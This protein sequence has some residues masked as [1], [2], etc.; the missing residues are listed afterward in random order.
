MKIQ[1]RLIIC[2]L[3][4]FAMQGLFV[5]LAQVYPVK[6]EELHGARRI[7]DVSLT[8]EEIVDTLIKITEAVEQNNI[9]L[10]QVLIHAFRPLKY[11]EHWQDALGHL[12]SVSWKAWVYRAIA[13]TRYRLQDY[14]KAVEFDVKAAEEFLRLGIKIEAA[15]S[16]RYAAINSVIGLRDYRRA[17]DYNVKSSDLYFEIGMFKEAAN[18]YEIAATMATTKLNDYAE[19]ETCRAKANK[20]Y[21]KT[22]IS[23][24]E[25]MAQVYEKKGQFQ[26][27]AYLYLKIAVEFLAKKKVPDAVEY[28]LKAAWVFEKAGMFFEARDCY[29]EAIEIQEQ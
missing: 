6:F 26:K 2:L 5:H 29:E 4:I 11:E 28:Y 22:G 23:R 18:G 12:S 24:D 19:A 14:G 7:K 9:G 8:R 21:S 13:V 10:A 16:F 25:V 27:A 17:I 15:N 3:F 20:C 1:V